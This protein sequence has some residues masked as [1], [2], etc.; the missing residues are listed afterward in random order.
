MSD[1]MS[2]RR[3]PW[4]F[5]LK[6][7]LVLCLIS[8]PPTPARHLTDRCPRKEAAP[9]GWDMPQVAPHMGFPVAMTM[10]SMPNLFLPDSSHQWFGR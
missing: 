6:R 4:P 2:T 8:R 3:R 9:S 5:W 7:L 10:N 1:Y